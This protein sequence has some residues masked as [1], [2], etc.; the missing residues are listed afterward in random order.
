VDKQTSLLL[1]VDVVTAGRL[2]L[3][4]RWRNV[5]VN[6]PLPEHIFTKQPPAGVTVKR[7]D[8]GFRRVTL[9]EAA[10][11]PGVTPLVPR[12]I[13]EGY[14][15]SQVAVAGR[16]AFTI[17]I[18]E[19]DEAFRGR[20]V[21]ALQYRRGFD[22]L[23]VS[24]RTI[25]GPDY[26]VDIDPCEGDQAWSTW[27]RTEVPIASGAFVGVTARILVG[28]TSSAPHLWAVKDGVLLTIAGAASAEELLAV[29]ESLQVYPGP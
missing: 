16:A 19:A 24:T 4:A 29:A 8:D 6:E 11:T 1:G 18:G 9:D 21:F 2:T 10:A 13:P 17:Q 12:V 5:R 28:S 7:I 3:S 14:A 15:L 20:H 25:D 23:T 27:A 22:A 26:T